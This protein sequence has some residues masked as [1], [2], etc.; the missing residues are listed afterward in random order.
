MKITEQE[1]KGGDN[2]NKD[3]SDVPNNNTCAADRANSSRVTLRKKSKSNTWALKTVRA[4]KCNTEPL[5]CCQPF[6]RSNKF[7]T[8]GWDWYATN[9]LNLKNLTVLQLIYCT[10][11]VKIWDFEKLKPTR[12]N[13]DFGIFFDT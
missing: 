8:G 13:D 5:S 10:S 4:M 3:D 2:D 11:K 9:R 1:N 6:A 12:V 7:V